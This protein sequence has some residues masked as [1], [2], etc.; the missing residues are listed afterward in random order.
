MPAQPFTSLAALLHIFT[1]ETGVEVINIYS[2]WEWTCPNMENTRRERPEQ[3]QHEE[4]NVQS[5]V[6][7]PRELLSRQGGK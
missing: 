2:Q 7:H 6:T 3:Y 1:A 4:Y 5:F